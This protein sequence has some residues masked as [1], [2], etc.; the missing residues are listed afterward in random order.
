MKMILLYGITHNG[1][2]ISKHRDS[3][4]IFLVFFSTRCSDFVY[5][6]KKR[7]FNILNRTKAI[8]MSPKTHDHI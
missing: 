2:F 4:V 5:V 3:V 6:N 8:I 1:E 7:I